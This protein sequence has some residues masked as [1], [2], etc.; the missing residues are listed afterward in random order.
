M[1]IPPKPD[2]W[3]PGYAEAFNL[4]V[5]ARAYPLRPPYP[6]GMFTTL[7]ALMVDQP[8]TL[9]D[10]GSGPGDLARNLVHA[11]E[12]VDAVDASLAMIERGRAMEHGN[13]PNLRWIHGRA[14]DTRLN[15]PYALVT[16]GD[17]SS[18]WI[19][20]SRCHGSKL[21]CLRTHRSPSSAGPGEPDS[22]RSAIS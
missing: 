15:P 1:T 19:G 10:L 18:G 2:C 7:A 13:H 14:E 20:R 4:D 11:A 9:L 12:R 8:R 16:A 17:S 22:R 6:E 5:V 21:L 3:A